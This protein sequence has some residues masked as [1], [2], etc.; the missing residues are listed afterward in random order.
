MS[1]IV[2]VFI[3]TDGTFEFWSVALD[4]ETSNAAQR[5]DHALKTVLGIE[6]R[7]EEVLRPVSGS[8]GRARF[9]STL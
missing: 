1:T 3:V 2:P 8:L 5:A 6:G 7:L 4:D 9:A